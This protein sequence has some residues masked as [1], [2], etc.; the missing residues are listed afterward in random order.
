MQTVAFLL[1]DV[2]DSTVLWEV[3]TEAMRAAVAEHDRIVLGAVEAAGRPG[4]EARR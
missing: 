4:R 3:Q 1:T 2:E